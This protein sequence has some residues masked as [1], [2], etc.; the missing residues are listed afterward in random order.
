MPEQ[1]ADKTPAW[2]CRTEETAFS[3]RDTS[4]PVVFRDQMW[5]SNAYTN[6]GILVRD[7]WNS[8]N[9]IDWRCVSDNTPYDGYSEMVVYQDKL[10][11]VKG[12]VW[13]TTD[14]VD[15]QQVSEATPFGVRG[16]GELLVFKDRMWQLGGRDLWH[17]TDGQQWECALEAPPCGARFGAA[18]TVFQDKLWLLGGAVEQASDPPEKHYPKFTTYND[19]WCSEDGVEW[20]RLV[21]HSPWAERMWVVPKVYAGRL[22]LIGG[23]SN[24]RDVNF[25][26]AWHTTD[27]LDWQEYPSD[28]IFSPRHE[29]SPY[30]FNGSLW[31]AAGNAWPLTNDVWTVTLP[32]G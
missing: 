15:W 31:V 22:W 19:V 9:G 12:S 10:W 4:E 17:T 13:N 24:R 20:T 1:A 26:E 16:Y 2:V 30:V 25:A 8:D 32:D 6:G 29:V 11:A 5:L 14:G 7:L 23:F 28:P 3:P 21:E 27:G 18:I